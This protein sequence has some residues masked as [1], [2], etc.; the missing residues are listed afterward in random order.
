MGMS[1]RPDNTAV[2][3]FWNIEACGTFLVEAKPG[4][5]EFYEAYRRI[6]YQHEP[7][8]LTLV[9][10]AECAGKSVLEIGTGNGADGVMFARAGAHYTGVDLT[11]AAIDATQRHFEVLGL[12]GRFQT[13]NAEALSFPDASFD[14]VYSHGVLH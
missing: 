10:F 14:F 3:E 4:T 6:R 7:H 5:A 1:S 8:I 2:S 11:Q 9:P 12:P 13:Q